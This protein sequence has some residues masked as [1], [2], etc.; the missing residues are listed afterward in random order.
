MEQVQNPPDFEQ[1]GQK[2]SKLTEVLD[3]FETP[4]Q[5][6]LRHLREN[7]AYRRFMEAVERG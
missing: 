5:A 6:E 4:E 7:E 2:M 1:I 3:R